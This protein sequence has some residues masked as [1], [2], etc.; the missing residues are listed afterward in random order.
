MDKLHIFCGRKKRKI[1]ISDNSHCTITLPTIWKLAC[2]F[3][4]IENGHHKSTF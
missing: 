4:E 1:K 3:N 2:D